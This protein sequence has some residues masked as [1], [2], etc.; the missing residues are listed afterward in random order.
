MKKSLEAA[1]QQ[2]KSRIQHK[3]QADSKDSSHEAMLANAMKTP[4]PADPSKAMVRSK[5][6][7]SASWIVRRLHRA[8]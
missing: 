2:R 4:T 8:R 1:S 7:S 3:K 5:S 6:K